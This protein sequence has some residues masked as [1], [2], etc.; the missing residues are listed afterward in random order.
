VASQSNLLAEIHTVQFLKLLN[1]HQVAERCQLSVSTVRRWRL[2]GT[3][4]KY[5]KIGYSARYKPEER[6]A[7]VRDLHVTIREFS[8]FVAYNRA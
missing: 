1:D 5:L 4:P 2:L 3:G 7:R 8:F 6:R